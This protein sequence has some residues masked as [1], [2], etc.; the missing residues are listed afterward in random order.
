MAITYIVDT[1]DSVAQT[2]ATTSGTLTIV[3]TSVIT[4]ILIGSD[5]GNFGTVT[6]E[7]SGTALTWT[8]IAQ[9]DT[10]SNCK[11]AGWWA[12]GDGNGNRTVT[13]QHGTNTKPRRLH[14]IVH[15]G[16]DQTTPV[17]AG[18]VLSGVSTTD[19]SNSM[20]PTNA[21]GSCLWLVC[22][23][24]NQS[25]SFAPLANCDREVADSNITDE[26]TTCL[27]RP[28][29]QPRTNGAAFTLGETDLATAI[30][31]IAFEV[32]AAEGAPS[33]V[34]ILGDRAL[35]SG[36]AAL[37]TECDKVYV[38]SQQPT[39]YTEAITTYG[40]GNKNWGVGNAFAAP[41]ARAG[42]GRQITSIAI[43]DGNVTADGTVA[44]WAA[45]DTVNSRL[46]AS[47]NMTG[48]KAV[49]NG[50]VF[51]LTAMTFGIPNA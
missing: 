5:N 8:P 42:G 50:Q 16:A 37:D 38:C 18:K 9:T 44:A 19:V 40:L 14:C 15:A 23:D 31:Y 46:L 36:L 21:N 11:L 6:I 45:V 43:T 20:T 2:G 29:T 27:L 26:Y 12:F 22:G 49:T 47:G 17:P 30:A 33:V 24:W 10:A 48:G 35:D 51:T 3:S 25:N 34:L 32:V 4:A 28:T 13:M 39:T 41:A 7:N 1:V